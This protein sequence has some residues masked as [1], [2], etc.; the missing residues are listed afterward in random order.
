[1]LRL[2]IRVGIFL[3]DFLMI[4]AAWYLAY[5]LRFNLGTIP[6]NSLRV[7]TLMLP[8]VIVCQSFSYLVFGLYRGIWRFA[9]LYDFI[10]IFKSAYVGALLVTLVI[11]AVTRLEHVPRSVI[12]LYMILLFIF[13]AGD[14]ALYRAFKA[15]RTRSS[16]GKRA[17]II[18]AGESAQMLTRDMLQHAQGEYLP[19]GMIDDNPDRLGREIHGIKVFGGFELIPEVV[20]KQSVDL[21]VIAIPS[22]SSARMQRLVGICENAGAQFK[23]PAQAC[24]PDLR[25][26]DRERHTGGLH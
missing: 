18:G 25:T 16:G 5:W 10:R 7:A 26:G 6:E 19:V 4:P 24:R 9:S 1:M 17:L 3:H 20:R 2:Y 11:F 21:I 23:D 12:P 8:A 14:R 15:R 22:L 13:V